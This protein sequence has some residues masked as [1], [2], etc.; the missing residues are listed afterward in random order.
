[1]KENKLIIAAAGAGKT[2]YLVE[3]AVKR[4]G[5]VL[6]TTFTEENEAEIY[7]KFISKYGF[8][9]GNVT[10]QTWFSFLLEHG[11]KPYQGTCYNDLF[12]KSIN[13]I[14]LVNQ[15][16]GLKYKFKKGG[17]EIPVYYSEDTEFMQH[18]FSK[19]MLLYT[20]KLAKFVIR[21][22]EKSNGNVIDRITRI[23]PTIFVDEVQDLAGYDLEII[24]ELYHSRASVVC[25]GDLRQVTYYTHSER[26]NKPYRQGMIKAYV[27][28]ESYRND[29]IDI[30]EHTLAYSHRNNQQI[31]T[32]SS[33]IYP[34]F[35][36]VLPCNCPECHPGN[37]PHQGVFLIKESDVDDYLRLYNP[38]QL[39]HSIRVETNRGYR[40]YNFGKSKGKTFERALIYPTRDIKNWLI[41]RNTELADR[42]RAALYVAVTRPRYSVAFVIPDNECSLIKDIEIWERPFEN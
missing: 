25:V 40:C 13:G 2:T 29:I 6:I 31:C 24:K 18:Y 12:E 35:P 39:R 22:N 19:E 10:I 1:M 20:D 38:V 23:Y 32:F 3:E 17:K 9:P 15:Q 7:D 33:L 8:V 41:N 37:V 30:D 27:Q 14:L 21:A 26:K 16:S 11:V 4:T 5:N 36:Q 28:N 42:T 34:S